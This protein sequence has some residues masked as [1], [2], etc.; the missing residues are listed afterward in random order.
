MKID[1]EIVAVSD[2][3]HLQQIYTGF[4]LLHRQGFLKLKQTLPCEFLENKNAPDRWENYRFVN[5]KVVVNGEITVCYD[6]HDWNWIDEEVLRETDFYFKRSYDAGYLSGLKE[7]E[8]VFPLGLNYSV[9]SPGTDLFKLERAAFYNGKDRIKTIVKGLRIDKFLRRG[10]GDPTRLDNLESYPNFTAEAKILFMARA[11]NPQGL[12]DKQQKE[13]V[14][15][16][17]ENRAASIRILRKEFGESFFGGLAHDDYSSSNFKDCLLPGENLSNKGK[18]LGILKNFPICVATS[19]L[20]KSNGWKLAEYVA[21]SK[22]IITEPLHFQV[23]GDFA[24]E[25]NYLQFTTPEELV[26]GATRLFEDKH[27]RFEMMMNN[28]RYYQSFVRPDALV[29]NTLAVVFSRR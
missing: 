1:C 22:A 27:R 20:N 7:K 26:E 24:K 15:A 10:A 11:W 23:T 14:Q 17:N 25:A 9:S 6:T 19:G 16:L 28:Y 21:F 18:Y 12:P 2:A 13:T 5:A 4:N 29:L 3:P 8:K